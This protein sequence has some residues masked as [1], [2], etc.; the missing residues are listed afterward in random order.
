MN[1]LNIILTTTVITFSVTAC[2]SSNTSG[3]S[4]NDRFIDKQ[5]KQIISENHLTGNVMQDR[6]TPDIS[7]PK[8]QLG[9]RLFFS[10]SLGGDQSVACVTCHHPALGGGIIFLYPL[11]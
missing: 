7:S 4:N 2:Q 5:L 6:Q 3:P 9:M 11:A 8:A 10:K 1:Y